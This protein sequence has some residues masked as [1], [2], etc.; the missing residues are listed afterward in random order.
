MKPNMRWIFADGEE[1]VL[2]LIKGSKF[3]LDAIG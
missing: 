2:S 1:S 3:L